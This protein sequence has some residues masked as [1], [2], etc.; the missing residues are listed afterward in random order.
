MCVPQPVCTRVPNHLRECVC[1][2]AG[3]SACI[4]GRVCASVLCD[5][6]RVYPCPGLSA[7]QCERG[8]TWAAPSETVRVHPYYRIIPFCSKSI[9]QRCVN[10]LNE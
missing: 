8:S 9:L 10:G 2:S 5:R 7:C 4:Y 6:V 3:V 1:G